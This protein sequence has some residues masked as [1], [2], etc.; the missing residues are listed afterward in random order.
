M[1]S[2]TSSQVVRVLRH[3]SENL[4]ARAW[5]GQPARLSALSHPSAPLPRKEPREIAHPHQSPGTPTAARRRRRRRDDGRRQCPG[6]DVRR[7]GR[8][9]HRRRD[10]QRADARGPERRHPRGR[11][12]GFLCASADDQFVRQQVI[13]LRRRAVR[14]LQRTYAGLPVV[15]GDF[16]VVTDNA[17]QVSST[18]SPRTTRSATVSTT[19]NLTSVQAASVAARPAEVRQQVE[20]T[21]LVVYA[22]G[23]A[24]AAL[25]WETTVDGTGSD[26]DSRL[27]VDVDARTGAVLHTQEHVE[28]GTGTGV[29]NGPNP[30]HDRHHAVGQHLL[31][32]TP[33]ITNM[34][35]QD[36]ANNTTFSKS[37]DT[38]G[39]GDG[40]QPGDR[41][42]RRAVRRADRVQDARAV[43]RPQRHGRQRRRLADPDRRPG[44][45]RLL[46]RHPGPG[47]LQLGRP[48]DRR[49]ST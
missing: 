15:G 38:W 32:D 14:P 8:R 13:I 35:C 20:G 4:A 27:S 11:T 16:V 31:D 34:P 6:D 10:P 43:A 19:P 26:G 42:R 39:N 28:H 3:L 49:A 5:V 7:G 24:P 37:T 9:S 12:S 47:R 17:G 36:A 45:E 1:P 18:R 40:H 46:R 25:A 21:T 30:L 48:V 2:V 41:L 44:G 23:A 29:W 33:N 22:L